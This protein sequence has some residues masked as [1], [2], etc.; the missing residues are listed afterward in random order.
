MEAD[1]D[2]SIM[3]DAWLT[4]RVRRWRSAPRS[5]GRRIATHAGGAVVT[6]ASW[7]VIVAITVEVSFQSS[8]CGQVTAQQSHTYRA[9]VLKYG[10]LGACVPLLVGALIWC[11]GERAWPWLVV[12]ALAAGYVLYSGLHAQVQQFCF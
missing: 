1:A 11:L 10:L 6:L 9:E 5:L 4:Q 3:S 7:W 8:V 2:I 12:A